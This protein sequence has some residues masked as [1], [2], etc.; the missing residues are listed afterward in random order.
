MR[1]PTQ[2]AAQ[3]RPA[4]I[5]Q[6]T[7]GEARSSAQPLWLSQPHLAIPE[8]PDAAGTSNPEAVA[9]ATIRVLHLLRRQQLF[10]TSRH[11]SNID[12]VR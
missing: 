6:A 4:C 8:L 9:H 3:R 5:A 10:A 11:R 1:G 12:P 7:L 2:L